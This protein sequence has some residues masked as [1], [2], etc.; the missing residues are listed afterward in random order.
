MVALFYPECDSV[1][2]RDAPNHIIYICLQWKGPNLETLP[3]A[4]KQSFCLLYGDYL[5]D[6]LLIA[7]E[8]MHIRGAMSPV[9]LIAFHDDCLGVF[10][11]GTTMSDTLPALETMWE[12]FVGLD[13]IGFI[14]SA[15]NFPQHLHLPF[16]LNTNTNDLPFKNL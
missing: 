2:P 3:Q 16:R 9:K 14:T 6:R 1:E 10:L 7:L 8:Y 13:P 15:C 5:E 12:R 4:A 11:D